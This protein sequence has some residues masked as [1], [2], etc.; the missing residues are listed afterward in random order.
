MTGRV[1]V[2]GVLGTGLVGQAPGGKGHGDIR[3]KRGRGLGESD[4]GTPSSM[5]SVLWY[6]P[7]SVGAGRRNE[8]PRLDDTGSAHF[9]QF[10]RLEG[11]GQ[12][13]GL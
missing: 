13:Q 11:H 10:W 3:N 1:C 4:L 7:L 9:S 2:E 6:E 12:M 5:P 8:Y